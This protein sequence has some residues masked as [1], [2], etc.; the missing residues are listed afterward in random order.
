MEWCYVTLKSSVGLFCFALFCLFYTSLWSRHSVESR[1][2]GTV[3]LQFK[4]L[5]PALSPFEPQ[6]KKKKKNIVNLHT[7][8]APNQ[9]A[10]Y[11]MNFS[12]SHLWPWKWFNH[13][14]KHIYCS[15][16][17]TP[18]C[19]HNRLNY[20]NFVSYLSFSRHSTFYF[21]RRKTFLTPDIWDNHMFCQFCAFAF[22]LPSKWTQFVY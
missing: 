2:Q 10:V 1:H 5:A 14:I 19:R 6:K 22:D 3:N 9:T 4:C 20:G 7:V 11:H 21:P 13:K 12:I 8:M 16:N 17:S 15:Q 18:G